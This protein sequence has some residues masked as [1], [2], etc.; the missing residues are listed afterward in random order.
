MCHYLT[1]PTFR[2][3]SLSFLGK[4]QF[5]TYP[6][7]EIFTKEQIISELIDEGKALE[8]SMMQNESEVVANK[9]VNPRK[10]K[11]R[12]LSTICDDKN[13]ETCSRNYNISEEIERYQKEDPISANDSALKWWKIKKSLYP[14]MSKLATKYLC[15][16]AMSTAAER[17]FS[18]LGNMVT[19]KRT[20]LSDEHV[21]KLSYLKDCI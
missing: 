17:A 5:D 19:K 11:S 7:R 13:E 9:T 16:Q 2:Y 15:V 18:T 12:F 14:V 21:Q 4:L 10:R 3:S 6:L 1:N 8:E 20:Q